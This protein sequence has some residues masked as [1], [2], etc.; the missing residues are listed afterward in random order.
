MRTSSS[1]MLAGWWVSSFDKDS[2]DVAGLPAALSFL[3]LAPAPRVLQLLLEVQGST[4]QVLSLLRA[5]AVP[6]CD[7]HSVCDTYM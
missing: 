7:I 3:F 6:V 4:L 2:L 5:G 1:E